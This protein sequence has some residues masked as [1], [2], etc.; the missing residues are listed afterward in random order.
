M[1]FVNKKK[2]KDI[3]KEIK[4]EDIVKKITISGIVYPNSSAN[5]GGKLVYGK[6]G[7][8]QSKIEK[9]V[10]A[11]YCVVD[12]NGNRIGWISEESISKKKDSK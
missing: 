5:V 7:F 11:P 3:E 6:K 2:N 12:E 1:I 9:E 10:P 4:K 8:I